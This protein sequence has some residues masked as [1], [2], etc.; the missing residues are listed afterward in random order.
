MWSVT[1]IS[2]VL[3][4]MLTVQITSKPQ[5]SPAVLSSYL[6]LRT[7]LLE[8]MQQQQVL[9]KEIAKENAQ[10]DQFKASNG[11]TE[12]LKKALENDAQTVSAE[13]GMMPLAGPGISISI[14][15]NPN[16]P[17]VADYAGKFQQYSDQEISQIVNDLFANG[18]KA[19]SINGQRLVTTSSIR[20]V[21]GLGGFSTLQINTYPVSMP[22]VI[23]AVGNVD[24]MQA[25]INVKQVVTLLNL[26]QEDC[27]IT[28]H[29]EANGITVPGYHGPLPGTWA[30]EVNHS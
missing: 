24:L 16:L 23:S 10:L 3:G 5:A 1:G 30:K 2:A 11:N 9:D 27:L 14:Q 15:D 6:D 22:Y 12:D 28:V 20:L 19:I 7:Q 25:V 4:F 8:Q 21:S 13:A 17:F 18:A 26:M 29:P